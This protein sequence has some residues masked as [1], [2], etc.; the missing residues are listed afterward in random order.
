GLKAVEKT[1]EKVAE[2]TAAPAVEEKATVATTL[3]SPIAGT[4]IPLT[5]VDDAAFASEA[6]GKGVAI[7]PAVGEVVSPING[8]VVMVFDT[9]H[10]IG[11]ESNEGVEILIHIGLDTVNLKGEGFTTHV[12]AGDLVE[13]GDKLVDFDI[14]FIKASGYKTT[15]PM[16]ITNT[17]NYKNIEV[18]AEGTVDLGDAIVTV[19]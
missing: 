6:L 8:K 13:I 1:E 12:K 16:V 14:D 3:R 18:V 11:L 4:A 7:E 19:Q 5:Q 10:A 9:K 17:F 2:T 15:T